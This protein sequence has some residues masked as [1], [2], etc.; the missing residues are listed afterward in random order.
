MEL[1]LL[2]EPVETTSGDFDSAARSA[3]GRLNQRERAAQPLIERPTADRACR[4]HPASVIAPGFIH[5]IS[6]AWPSGSQKL[7]L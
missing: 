5:T 3:R 7:R 4:D 6:Q 1:H 2:V